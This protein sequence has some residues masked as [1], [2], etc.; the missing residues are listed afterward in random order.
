MKVVLELPSDVEMS[1]R[2]GSTVFVDET[3]ITTTAS[4]ELLVAASDH[5]R[6][7]PLVALSRSGLRTTETPLDGMR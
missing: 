5:P 4:G 1:S 6:S 2:M 3:V 7:K